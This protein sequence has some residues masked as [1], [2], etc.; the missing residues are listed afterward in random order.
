MGAGAA[1]TWMPPWARMTATAWAGRA[2]TAS[3]ANSAAG[4]PIRQDTHRKHGVRPEAS[5]LAR[6]RVF[7]N[8]STLD[9]SMDGM[10]P[11]LQIRNQRRQGQRAEQRRE[12]HSAADQGHVQIIFDRQDRG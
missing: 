10:L 9:N 3:T 8:P 5:L 6:R 11:L 2:A 7:G 4:K 12:H 1:M